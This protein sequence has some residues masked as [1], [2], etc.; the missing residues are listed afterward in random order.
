MTEYKNPHLD[1]PKVDW[2][3]IQRFQRDP[4]GVFE[5]LHAAYGGLVSITMPFAQAYLVAEP[6]LIEHVLVRDHG[7][8]VKD[9]FTRELRHVMG[10]GLL[11]SEHAT[12]RRNRK[13]ASPPFT[14]RAISS[15]ALDMVAIADTHAG[16]FTPDVPRDVHKDLMDMTLEIVVRS[17][18]GSRLPP[19]AADVGEALDTIMRFFTE[20]T[21]SFKR[22]IP[23]WLPTPANLRLKRAVRTIDNV[24][25]SIIADKHARQD[26][27]ANDLVTLLMNARD[28]HGQG[29]TDSEL[30]DEV[31]TIFLAGHETT[32]LVLSYTLLALAEHP[33]VQRRAHEEIDRLGKR[34]V[35]LADMPRLPFI[36][37]VLNESMR[38]Y[39]PAWVVAREA[40][41]DTQLGGHPIRKGSQV[42]MS[43]WLAHRDA[44][45]FPNPTRFDPDR[46]STTPKDALAR[47]A[48]FPFGGGPRVCIGSHMAMMEAVLC[49]ATI[50]QKR[51]FELAPDH[52]T[53]LECSMT[54]RPARGVKLV[55][56]VR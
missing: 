4:L 19:E 13:I 22:L 8:Y 39:P 26:G 9:Q 54:L 38:L 28:E 10:A 45:S 20:V 44:T 24:I 12:W 32:A 40:I 3:F 49:L 18:L 42:W 33:D 16:R 23:K 21:R 51:T 31:I 14:K 35:S 2:R 43:Q 7:S 46:W 41:A 30:R 29:L 37:S 6:S 55:P 48:Y 1:G 34:P 47:F 52:V 56:R 25:T 5:E 11:T 15:Y 53:E 50:L 27:A 17:V 36:E